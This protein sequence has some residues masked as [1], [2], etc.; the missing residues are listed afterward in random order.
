MRMV[1]ALT[2][3][4]FA[5]PVAAQTAAPAAVDPARLAAATGLVEVVMPPALRNRMIEQ[6]STTMMTNMQSAVM[7][8]PNMA[9]LFETQPKA[10][11][12]F[13]R[14]LAE[15]VVF[16]R[17][18]MRDMMPTMMT[19]AAR[20][21]ARRLTIAQMDKAKAFFATP[22]GQAYTLAAT[23]VLADPEYAAMMQQIMSR[24]MTDMQPRMASV[25][26]ELRALDMPA[27]KQ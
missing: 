26:A 8:T 7:N 17:T 20:S 22:D 4:L 15:Q 1:L 18:T 6:T 24:M 16:M 13:E 2:L 11:P 25:A 14:F 21:Y 9:K 3:L 10:K 19:A 12:I 23:D 27:A 5:A